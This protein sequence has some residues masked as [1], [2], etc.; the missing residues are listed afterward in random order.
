MA[1]G[2][3]GGRAGGARGGGARGFGHG[4]ALGGCPARLHAR[5]AVAPRHRAAGGAGGAVAGQAGLAGD[6]GRA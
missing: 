6:Q 1:G 5:G 2:V 4:P 3:G